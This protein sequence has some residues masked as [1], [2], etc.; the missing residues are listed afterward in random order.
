MFKP[1]FTGLVESGK[2]CQT[3]RPTPKRLPKAGDR[4]SLRAWSGRPYRSKQLVLREAQIVAV[5]K[6]R[7][8][9]YFFNGGP[10][11]AHGKRISLDAFAQA[12][13]FGCWQELQTWFGETHGLPFEGIVIYWS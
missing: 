13:G 9:G 7:F 10:R 12:D 2:K 5:R 8:A 3:V 1:Q 6:I 11:D 4:I